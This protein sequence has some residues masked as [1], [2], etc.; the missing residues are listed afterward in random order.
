MIKDFVADKITYVVDREANCYE[1]SFSDHR[2][3]P[4]QY[5]IAQRAFFFD[6]QDIEL[7]MDTYYF[8]YADQS[9]SGYG[10]CSTV[11]LERDR[12]VFKIKNGALDVITEIHIKFK[13]TMSVKSWGELAEV[14]EKIFDRRI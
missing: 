14:F 3:E 12:A 4:E 2:D 1:I 5:V 7:G 8:E 10:I 6:K 11:K 9:S 13:N